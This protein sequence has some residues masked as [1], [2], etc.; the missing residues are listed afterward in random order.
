MVIIF[1]NFY[2]STLNLWTPRNN[3]RPDNTATKS[4]AKINYRAQLFEGRLALNLGFFFLCSKH[5]SDN[6]L[7][8]F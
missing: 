5:F 1:R 8:Y 3:G 4:S 7:C 6:F 2:K